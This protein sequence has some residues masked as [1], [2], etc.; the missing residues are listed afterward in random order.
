MNSNSNIINPKDWILTDIFIKNDKS[1]LYNVLPIINENTSEEDKKI[2][3][4]NKWVLKIIDDAYELNIINE[5]KL[6]DNELIINIKKDSFHYDKKNNM[7]WY[8]MEKYDGNIYNNYLF[9]QLNLIKLG[10]YMIKFFKYLHLDNKHIHGDIKPNNIVYSCSNKD[11]PFK[12]ID[13]ESTRKISRKF[14]CNEY[15]NDNYY[16]YYIGCEYNKPFY[17]YRM[18]LESFGCILYS[19]AVS[20][21]IY[22]LSNWQL[23]AIR[24]YD[25]K[26]PNQFYYLH[27]MRKLYN[28]ENKLENNQYKNII[29][30]YFNII[31]KQEWFEEPNQDVYKELE[32]LFTII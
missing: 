3:N 13:Y 25:H 14:L 21:T 5:L 1:F 23:E 8:I 16:F 29:L 24:C 7:F 26:K 28:K 19:I 6:Y 15:H 30:K 32:E 20:D 17:S 22:Y 12:I 11:Y 10:N 18:D 9:A 4:N 31:K 27:N 2:L